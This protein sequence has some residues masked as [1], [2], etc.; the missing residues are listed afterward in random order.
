MFIRKRSGFMKK[1][2]YES[3]VRDAPVGFAFFEILA[4]AKGN[5]Y[6]Y[7]FVEANKAF[8]NII[9]RKNDVLRGATL[10]ELLPDLQHNGFDWMSFYLKLKDNIDISIPQ[11]YHRSLRRWYRIDSYCPEEGFL[12]IAFIDISKEKKEIN[13]LKKIEKE[14]LEFENALLEQ[15][16]ALELAKEKAEESDH[17]RTAFLANISHE[18]RTPMNG[19]LG[20]LQLIKEPN[21]EGKLKKKYIDIVNISGRRLLGTINDI[22]EISLIESGPLRMNYSEVNLAQ[23]MKNQYT[24]FRKE[25]VTRQVKLHLNNYIT[26]KKAIIRTDKHKLSAALRYLL[27]NAFKFTKKGVIEFGNDLIDNKLNFYVKDTGEGIP[28]EKKDIIFD[29]FVQADMKFNRP[30]EGSGLGLPIAKA[31]IEALDGVIWVESKPGN[32]ST[33]Y[34][35][36]PYIPVETTASTATK[37]RQFKQA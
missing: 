16:A 23:L 26:G 10:C 18:I 9:G 14:L 35:S 32:G 2:Q 12:S 21:L 8:E 15:N 6:D 5:P 4:D 27:H 25:S 17:L 29:R 28:E 24:F 20:F 13:K 19:I 33:F 11:Q 31:Y 30:Y 22:V 3:V 7:R 36:V 34:F 37:R 1:S